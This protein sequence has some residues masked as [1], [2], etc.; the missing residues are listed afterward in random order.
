MTNAIISFGVKLLLIIGIIFGAHIFV[1]SLI[2]IPLFDNRII[3][4]YIINF[5]LAMVIYIALYK[6][7]KKYLDILGFIFMGG[8]L[9]KFVAYF[10]FFY[11]LY[12][13]DGTI[14]S[15]EATAFLAPYA[16]CLF[17]ETFYLIKLLNK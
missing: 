2:Q 14:N 4:A 3:L 17:F 11:P 8:S 9:L 12:K 16:G 1:L 13:E 5:L 7:K 6:L 10:I 15:F